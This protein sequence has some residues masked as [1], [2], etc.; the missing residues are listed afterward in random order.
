MT[1]TTLH[2][3]KHLLV[4]LLGSLSPS[5]LNP[6]EKFVLIEIE[7]LALLVSRKYPFAYQCIYGRLGFSDDTASIFYFY[8]HMF[9]RWLWLEFRYHLFQL[10]D[11]FGQITYRFGQLIKCYCFF[12][13]TPIVFNCSTAK[14]TGVSM[15]ESFTKI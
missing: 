3:G 11:L 7:F 8:Q 1:H 5:V 14:E 6:S 2:I 12:L 9:V 15:V 10:D 4:C 13:H